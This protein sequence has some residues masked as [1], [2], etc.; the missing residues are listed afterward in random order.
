MG[1]VM[2]RYCV[3]LALLLGLAAT[4][5]TLAEGALPAPA[6]AQ[7]NVL[8]KPTL[9]ARLAS[10]FPGVGD[11]DRV[12]LASCEECGD[13]A[14]ES[15][16]EAVCCCRKGIYGWGEFLYLNPRDAEVAFAV[17]VNIQTPGTYAVPVGQTAVLDPDYSPGF[18]VGFAVDMAPCSRLG[19]EFTHFESRTH[20]E[21]SAAAPNV[22][23]S[24]VQVPLSANT[25]TTFGSAEGDLD[26]DFDLVDIDYRHTFINGC[27]HTMNY[28]VGVRYGHL[29]QNLRTSFTVLGREDV[30]SDI[31]F[32]GGG[33]RFGLEAEKHSCTTGLM[34]YAKAIGSLVAGDFQA[35]YSQSRN[36]GP[37]N[38][39]QT[40]WKAGRV[41]TMADMELGMGWVS[42]NGCLR[43]TGG[44]TFSKW[45][46]TVMVDEYIQAV[47]NNDFV[48]L[49]DEMTFDGLVARAEVR[50]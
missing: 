47:Q 42:C 26:I 44:Y 34:I 10:Y 4:N 1:S 21:A 25:I 8:E 39:I 45:F 19:A 12:T 24:R 15:C 40:G 22:L 17:P 38:E 31:T 35:S 46:N 48:G 28:L 29:D 20:A 14:C 36:T 16:G 32:D 50:F 41:V 13:G 30:I 11:T 43:L 18:R 2:M 9:K 5:T 23:F 33:I 7:S 37:L 49:G 27:S 6:F 3:V